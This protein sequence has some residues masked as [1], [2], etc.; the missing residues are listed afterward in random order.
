MSNKTNKFIKELI[1]KNPKIKSGRK[2]YESYQ[3]RI[4]ETIKLI[5]KYIKK[6]NN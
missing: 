4:S 3:L 1:D 6:T 5:K 2:D